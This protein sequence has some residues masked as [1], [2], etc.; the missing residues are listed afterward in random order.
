MEE[1]DLPASSRLFSA[2]GHTNT[3]VIFRAQ[4]RTSLRV[5]FEF[6]CW[7]LG[8]SFLLHLH[9]TCQ[10]RRDLA[11]HEGPR[12]V[13]AHEGALLPTGAVHLIP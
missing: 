9:I 5:R 8:V 7:P 3:A 10:D 13:G 6:C 11:L 1:E 4:D 12:D 2:V